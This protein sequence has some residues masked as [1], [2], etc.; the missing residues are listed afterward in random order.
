M[1]DQF[2]VIG[3]IQAALF[4]L[5]LFRGDGMALL[6]MNWKNGQPPKNFVGF[7]IQYREP[8]GDKFY[9]L[10]NRLC[11]SKLDGMVNPNQLSSLLSPFQKFRWVHFPH[12]AEL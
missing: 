12:N 4:T 11:F 1:Q 5:K 7:A 2:E 8:G 6:G 10:I 9:S 3:K